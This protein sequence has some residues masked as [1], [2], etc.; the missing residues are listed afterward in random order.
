MLDHHPRTI[1]LRKKMRLAELVTV[2]KSERLKPPYVGVT[3]DRSSDSPFLKFFV[4]SLGPPQ[5]TSCDYLVS[6]AARPCEIS[7]HGHIQL[8]N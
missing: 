7:I 4:A 1:I 6:L 2:F 8:L 5:Y 3:V